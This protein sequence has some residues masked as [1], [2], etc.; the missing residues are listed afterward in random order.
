MGRPRK[1][2]QDS[3]VSRMEAAFFRVME[4]TPFGKLTVRAVV[5]EAGVNRNSFYYHYAG[6]DDLA[7]SA[8]AN[9]LVPEIP[10]MILRGLGPGSEQVV[11]VLEGVHGDDRLRKLLILIG[12]NST[13]ALRA[14]LKDAVLDLWLQTFEVE[15]GDL[16]PEESATVDFLLAGALELVGQVK[17]SDARAALSRLSSIPIVQESMRIAVLTLKAAGTRS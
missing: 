1:D 5:T 12:P 4:E 2:G 14:M 6:I 11:Q 16:T 9:L 3:A 15:R 10:R 8:V 7:R 17:Q 13:S